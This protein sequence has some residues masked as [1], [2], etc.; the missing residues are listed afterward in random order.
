MGKDA[1]LSKL[2]KMR[3]LLSRLEKDAELQS[4]HLFEVHRHID[5]LERL[6]ERLPPDA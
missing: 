5:D 1:L 4:E 6:V 2:A 3:R